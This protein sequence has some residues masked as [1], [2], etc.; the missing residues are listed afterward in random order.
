[1]SYVWEKFQDKTVSKNIYKKSHTFFWAPCGRYQYIRH[2]LLNPKLQRKAMSFNNHI[3]SHKTLK[4]RALT[5]VFKEQPLA[6]L[7]SA[8]NVTQ[9]VQTEGKKFNNYF[10]ISN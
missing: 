4:D 8:K 2:L 7:E 6:L 3:S 9:P 5:T 10:M 1:M